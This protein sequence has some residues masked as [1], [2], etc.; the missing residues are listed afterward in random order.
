MNRVN[1]SLSRGEVILFA[2]ICSVCIGLHVL[3]LAAAEPAQQNDV[4][5]RRNQFQQEAARLRNEFASNIPEEA[6]VKG[7]NGEVTGVNKSHPDYQRLQAE[8]KTGM[9]R[10]WKQSN[11]GDTRF[12]EITEVCREAGIEQGIK[13]SGSRP[14]SINSDVD[15]TETTPGAG[16]KLADGLAKQDYTVKELIDRWIIKEIDTTIWKKGAVEQAGSE[17]HRAQQARNAAAEDI[18]A[19]E[20]GKY[21]TSEGEMGPLGRTTRGKVGVLDPEGAVLAN[22]KKFSE[23]TR[24]ST[25]SSGKAVRPDLP[26][27]LQQIDGH[28]AGKSVSK[29]AEWTGM[30]HRDPE[31]FKQADALRNHQSWEDAGVC[32]HGDPPEVKARKVRDF[33]QKANEYMGE[34][35]ELATTQSRQLENMR[36]KTA[37][38]Y[39]RQ[40][41]P[42]EA[43]RVREKTIRAR[44][45]NQETMRNLVQNDP[46]LA[47]Q[48]RGMKV[49]RNPD[50]TF[51]EVNSGRKMSPS[52]LEEAV[53][54]PSRSAS[55]ES[56]REGVEPAAEPANEQAKTARST[57]MKWGGR[58]VILHAAYE[59]S[60]E[61]A[62]EAVAEE[63]EGDSGL[64]TWTKAT[65]YGIWHTTGIPGAWKTGKQAGE[66]SR[67]QFEKDLKAGKN[68]SALWSRVRAVGWGVGRFAKGLF[69]DPLVQGAV[70]VKEGVGMVGDTVSAHQKAQASKDFLRRARERKE[71]MASQKE[72]A[73]KRQSRI[74][75]TAN[76][77]RMKNVPLVPGGDWLT[78]ERD[79][80][81]LERDNPDEYKHRISLI[82]EQYDKLRRKLK[83]DGVLAG[84]AQTERKL[85]YN[86]LWT[87]YR[88]PDE[89][90]TKLAEHYQGFG[91]TYAVAPTP[92][93]LNGLWSGGEFTV[94]DVTIAEEIIQGIVTAGT[95]PVQG[96]DPEKIKVAEG[97]LRKNLPKKMGLTFELRGSGGST[98]I[99]NLD[100][101]G[102]DVEPQ[103]AQQILHGLSY[104][105]ANGTVTLDGSHKDEKGMLLVIHLVGNVRRAGDAWLLGGAWTIQVKFEGK[106]GFLMKGTW[107]GKK[108]L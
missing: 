27:D 63:K 34:A 1:R 59:G 103:K 92:E 71:R 3:D 57:L 64:R 91:K 83:E 31:F 9:E 94:T 39:E 52:Q 95:A 72:G 5:T 81:R 47:A 80:A 76:W 28:T 70:A 19:T 8:Y 86:L 55:V 38:S 93:E 106:T 97:N 104:T 2:L 13:N 10:A 44:V 84:D 45:S 60:K 68:P 73:E 11:Q 99:A 62:K 100:V 56:A 79:N 74:I 24:S 26:A 78:A 15:L 42:E 41:L 101:T 98:G 67:A 25:S 20:G 61:G 48:L 17:A 36:N 7:P 69:V 51:T 90:E 43:A 14:K 23:A 87:K 6:F 18:F 40:G 16:R 75:L 77:A 22:A 32:D 37:E 85:I 66:E 107:S 21:R 4:V 33:V 46:E 53:V 65:L 49:Q 58:A 12:E 88:H 89:F 102:P 108:S 29:A 54:K 50:G 30:K 82:L 105:Y 35:S 96:C